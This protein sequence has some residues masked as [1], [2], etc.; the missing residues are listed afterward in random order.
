M[1]VD[2]FPAVSF[3]ANL[4]HLGLSPDQR[5]LKRRGIAAAL[6][7]ESRLTVIS[8][9][10]APSPRSPESHYDAILVTGWASLLIQGPRWIRCLLQKPNWY[11]SEML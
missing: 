4:D 8:I 3:L 5:L 2:G 6:V 7:A 11:E 9:D 10:M 1:H